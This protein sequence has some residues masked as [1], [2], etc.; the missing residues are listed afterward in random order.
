MDTFCDLPGGARTSGNTGAEDA[1]D[2][3]VILLRRFFSGTKEDMSRHRHQEV[4]RQKENI[5]K[6]KK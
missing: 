2:F 5:N 6:E 3:A 4:E 1:G